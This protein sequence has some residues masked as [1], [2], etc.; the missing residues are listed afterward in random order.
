MNHNTDIG[1]SKLLRFLAYHMIHRAFRLLPAPCKFHNH[2]IVLRFRFRQLQ[3]I[4][5]VESA[6]YSLPAPELC[7]L[8]LE[9]Q[10]QLPWLQS[11]LLELP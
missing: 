8:G 9:Q 4:A 10:Q 7:R 11:L 6:G 2:L 1:H 5:A 3:Y